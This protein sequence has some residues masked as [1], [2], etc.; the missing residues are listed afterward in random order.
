MRSQGRRRLPARAAL[1]VRPARSDG[2]TARSRWLARQRRDKCAKLT[3]GVED[4]IGETLTHFLPLAQQT[5]E[6]HHMLERINDEIRRRTCVV[7]IF[8]N[9]E[10][11]LRVVRALTMERHEPWLEDQ[12]YLNMDLLKEY[13]KEAL[14]QAA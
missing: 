5:H 13:K 12:G 7:R 1:D 4:N 14:R 2:G 10:S 11:C 6:V 9:V 3:G 8:P